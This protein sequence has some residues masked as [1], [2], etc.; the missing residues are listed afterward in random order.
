MAGLK[1]TGY[2]KLDNNTIDTSTV[3]FI[4]WLM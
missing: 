1:E 2:V 4:V 3:N